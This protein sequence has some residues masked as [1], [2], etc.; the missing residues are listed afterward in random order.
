[1]TLGVFSF[2]SP[3][4]SCPPG[5]SELPRPTR[6]NWFWQKKC[7]QP[8]KTHKSLCTKW[9]RQKLK[10]Y[11]ASYLLADTGAFY[12]AVCIFRSWR[13]TFCLFAQPNTAIL[14]QSH[15]II[16]SLQLKQPTQFNLTH[17][18]LT[19]LDWADDWHDFSQRTPVLKKVSVAIRDQEV[20]KTL[21][22][23]WH[24]CVPA[25]DMERQ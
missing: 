2:N 11:A 8:G 5:Q 23:A 10:F 16:P 20:S 7:I 12:V 13:P 24:G 22:T 14:Q 18:T 9:S 4:K 19:Q 6:R 25:Q 17:A 1:M 3:T 15:V 21:R